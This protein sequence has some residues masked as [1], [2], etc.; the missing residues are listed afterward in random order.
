[1]SFLPSLSM[2]S[3]DLWIIPFICPYNTPGFLSVLGDV[4]TNECSLDC[5]NLNK[6]NSLI[7]WCILSLTIPGWIIF[8]RPKGNSGLQSRPERT[9]KKKGEKKKEEAYGGISRNVLKKLVRARLRNKRKI[10]MQMNGHSK[11]AALRQASRLQW[12]EQQGYGVIQDVL[13]GP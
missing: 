11:H 4:P 9:E 12:G 13:V 2:V 5:S 3:T 6:I 7:V 8:S 10:Y 1:M